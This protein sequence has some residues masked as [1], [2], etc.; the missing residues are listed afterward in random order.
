MFTKLKK[1]TFF[2]SKLVPNCPLW[3]RQR[4]IRNFHIVYKVYNRNIP[5]HVLDAKFQFRCICRSQLYLE[6]ALR[7]FDLG[8]NWTHF[9]GGFFWREEGN[10][11]SKQHQIELKFWPQLVLIVAQMLFKAFWKT[12]IF[13][14]TGDVPNV[15]V[16]GPKLVSSLPHEDGRN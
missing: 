14:E 9:V 5:L 15:L 11:S 8:L 16:F 6:E 1:E 13:T 4:V 10:N 7:F 2:P 3:L 12:R